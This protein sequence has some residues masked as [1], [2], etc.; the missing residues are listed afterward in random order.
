MY[1]YLYMYMQYM[2]MQYMSTYIITVSQKKNFDVVK[3][4]MKE[5]V[6]SRQSLLVSHWE[7]IVSHDLVYICDVQYMYM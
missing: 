5:I 6:I 3:A 1:M 2:Y 7:H 4:V